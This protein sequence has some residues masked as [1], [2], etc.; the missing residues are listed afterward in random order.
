[1]LD[2]IITN[3]DIV[4]ECS[5]LD[6]NVSDH[7]PVYLIRKKVKSPN[8]KIDFKGRSYKNLNKDVVENML[9]NVDWATFANFDI[10]SCWNYLL[11][12]I[13]DILDNVCPEKKI[14]FAKNRP[15]WLTNDL[16]NLMKERDRLL[17]VY[18]KSK[19]ENDKKEMRK[20]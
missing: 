13:M 3:C 7:L 19:Q 15:S 2:L 5:T 17:K 1:M 8:E 11:E 10:D 12:N 14:K 18:Q 9:R 16:I 4:K 6:I 20:F